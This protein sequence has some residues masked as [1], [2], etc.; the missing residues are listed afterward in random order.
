MVL[1]RKHH[2]APAE[3][4]RGRRQ[5]EGRPAATMLNRTTAAKG[6]A[7]F[8]QDGIDRPQKRPADEQQVAGIEGE[9]RERLQLPRR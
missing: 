9:P 5:R 3:T 8:Q 6:R 7:P 2:R 4:P 1:V